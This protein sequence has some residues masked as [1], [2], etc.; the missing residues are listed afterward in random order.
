MKTT[1]TRK[2]NGIQWI[3][4]TQRDDLG[5]ADNLALL[6]HNH[7]QMQD[8]TTKLETTP[9]GVGLRV[10]RKANLMKINTSINTTVTVGGKPI[11]EVDSFTYLGSIIDRQGAQT[12]TSQPDWAK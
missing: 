5:F 9:L 10:N 2:K 11:Q 12:A 8:K 7:N 4:W 6:S 1:T 3:L